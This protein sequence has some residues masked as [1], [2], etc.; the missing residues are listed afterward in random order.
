MRV[1]AHIMVFVLEMGVKF[2][3]VTTCPA[4]VTSIGQDP[5]LLC[6]PFLFAM[7]SVHLCHIYIYN[8]IHLTNWQMQA[9]ALTITSYNW[10]VQQ[11]PYLYNT[12]Q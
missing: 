2:G 11:E 5:C 1:G 6:I 12:V 9:V 7:D 4:N 10:Q 8:I 3:D